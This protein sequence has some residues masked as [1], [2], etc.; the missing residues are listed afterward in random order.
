MYTCSE[1]HRLCHRVTMQAAILAQDDMLE[2]DGGIYGS[3]TILIS[4]S[5]FHYSLI[6]ITHPGE[7]SHELVDRGPFKDP[8]S[9]SMPCLVLHQAL[10]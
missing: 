4:L 2:N 6:S 1:E 9:S 10:D 7:E 3:L 8:H 5:L